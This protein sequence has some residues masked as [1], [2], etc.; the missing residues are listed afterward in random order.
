MFRD[1]PNRE[2][3]ISQ[4]HY[5]ESVLDK[6]GLLDCSP[7][8]TPL[9]TNF[10][11]ISA[12]DNGFNDVC[13]ADYRAIVGSVMYAAT[14]SQPDIAHAAG[15]LARYASKW[16]KDHLHVARHL[17]CY[18]RGTSELCLTFD[19]TSTYRTILGHADAGWGG[20]FNTWRSTTG[21]L[22]QTFGGPV[23]WKSH[24]SLVDRRGWIQVIS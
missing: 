9:P 18:L 20:C 23:A 3:Y 11:S 2:L 4:E 21:Y 16:N 7:A 13:N 24:N 1:R 5:I 14:I 6:F 8:K 17:L 19:A 10:R 12:M 22:F 15:L